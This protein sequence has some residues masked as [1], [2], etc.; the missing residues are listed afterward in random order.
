[1]TDYKKDFIR[2]MLSAGAL[3]F[4]DFTTKSG[5]KTPYFINTGA[6]RTGAHLARLG[7]FY[8]AAIAEGYPEGG[9]DNLFGPAYKGIPLAV[10]ASIALQSGHGR[11]VTVT[12][13]RKEAK[14]HGEGGFLVGF[15]YKAWTESAPCRVLLI[16]DVTT[17]GTSVRESLPLIEA[18]G[19]AKAV[20]LVVSVDRM[21]KGA[22]ERPALR[23][24]REDFGLKTTAIVSVLD[25]I[26]FLKTGEGSEYVARDASLIDR[27]LEYREKYGAE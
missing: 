15:D 19:K 11:D 26:A 16:E 14:D 10:T 13:N 5:R 27:M 24:I 22:G 12:F 23:E 1:M 17:A 18:G 6:Y 2:F 8:A 4:G 25:L 20:G 7:E 3:R 21:E 9:F